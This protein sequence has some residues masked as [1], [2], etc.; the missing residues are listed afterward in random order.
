MQEQKKDMDHK[1]VTANPSDQQPKK[2][3]D[4]QNNSK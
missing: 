3:D 1:N 2:T 4:T